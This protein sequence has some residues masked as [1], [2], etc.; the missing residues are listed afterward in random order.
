MQQHLQARVVDI[1]RAFPD[2]RMLTLVH[3]LPVLAALGRSVLVAAGRGTLP[4][5]LIA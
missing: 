4:I 5:G 3:R 1:G 2:L